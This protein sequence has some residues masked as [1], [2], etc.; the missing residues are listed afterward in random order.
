MAYA[1]CWGD[2]GS[3]LIQRRNGGEGMTQRRDDA[4]S[5]E[6]DNSKGRQ[7]REERKGFKVLGS[8]VRVEALAWGGLEGLG[9][10]GLER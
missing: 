8:R 3:D 4:T 10:F 5:E 2:K 1:E 6:R 7:G 9:S